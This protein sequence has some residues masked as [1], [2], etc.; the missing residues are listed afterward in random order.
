MR[1]SPSQVIGTL[2]SKLLR[3]GWKR[4]VRAT[5]REGGGLNAL[6]VVLHHKRVLGACARRNSEN[7]ERPKGFH[8]RSVSLFS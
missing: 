3:T 8:V 5:E 6:L 2:T 4:C 7:E 1:P